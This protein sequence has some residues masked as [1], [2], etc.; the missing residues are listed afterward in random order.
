MVVF[1]RILG[2]LT[3]LVVAAVVAVAGVSLMR[4]P[5][6]PG[7]NHPRAE[8]TASPAHQAPVAAATGL[9]AV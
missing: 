1:H 9:E 8:L 5:L 3:G 2:V 4:P 6:G 7:T